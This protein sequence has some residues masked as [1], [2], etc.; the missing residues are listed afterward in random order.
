MTALLG[1][2]LDDA[3]QVVTLIRDWKLDDEEWAAVV[4]ALRRLSDALAGGDEAVAALEEAAPPRLAP[5][6]EPD[7]AGPKEAPDEVRHLVVE[8]RRL[9]DRSRTAR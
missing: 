6:R 5:Y 4:Q 7:A 8:I 3:D 2:T 9:T 1:E